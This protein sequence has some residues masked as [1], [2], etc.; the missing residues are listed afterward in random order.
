M[1]NGR[2]ESVLGDISSSFQL[3]YSAISA[4]LQDD[5]DM[6]HKYFQLY[7]SAIGNFSLVRV[8]GVKGEK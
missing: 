2:K 7:D 4:L 6:M 1:K 8:W 3:N 5:V